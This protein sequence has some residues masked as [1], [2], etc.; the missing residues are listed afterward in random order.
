MPPEDL[1]RISDG[2][3]DAYPLSQVQTGMAVEVLLEDA[4]DDYHRVTSFRVRDEHPF[5]RE[6]LHSAARTVV[7]RH[8]ILRTSLALTGFSVPLQLVHPEAEVPF[9]VEDFTELDE[10]A[11]RDA[12]RA[13]IKREEDSPFDL[14]TAPL[15]RVAGLVEGADSWSLV[16][17]H[18]HIILEGWSHH[19]LLMEILDVYRA[20]RDGQ[21][22]DAGHE[23]VDVRFADFI[24][25]ELASLDDDADRA[26]WQRVVDEHSAMALPAAGATQPPRAPPS[27]FPSRTATSKT[28]SV[29]S[30]S[31]P[32][33]R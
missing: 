22:R 9:A 33:S 28:A 6:A 7:A 12:V 1:D 29:P 18:S 30:P 19:S 31:G 4:G 10:P 27:G 25:G 5:S 3:A 2:L 21:D 23:A 32:A 17:T 15:L 24:A 26:Y 14:G 16:L 8:E 11:T 20:V 13:Y